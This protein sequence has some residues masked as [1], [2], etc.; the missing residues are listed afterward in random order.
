M[1]MRSRNNGIIFIMVMLVLTGTLLAGC[2]K[3]SDQPKESETSASES[4]ALESTEIP[5]E[6]NAEISE[7]AMQNFLDKLSNGNYTVDSAGYLKTTAYSED[8]V[9]FDYEDDE[10]YNDFAVMSVDHEVFQGSLEEDV[11]DVSFLREGSAL[12]TVINRLPGYWMTDEASGGNIYNVFYNDT[13]D[14]LKFV[15][16]DAGIQDHVRSLAGYGQVAVNYMH[17]VYLSMDQEDPEV[18]H[19]QAVVD[20]DEVARYYFD[21]IDITITF[22]DAQPDARAEAWMKAP[23]YPEARTQW[24]ES[25][26]FVFNSVFLPGYGDQAIPYIPFASYAL[27]VDEERFIS[28]DAVYIRDSHATQEDTENYQQILIDNGYEACTEDDGTWYRK[29]LRE[30]T[31]CYASISA[32]Y[33]DGLDVTAKKYYDFP[34]YE[35]LE[36]INELIAGNGYPGLSETDAMTV[37]DATD[38]KFEQTESWLYFYDYDIVLYVNARYEDPDQ[39]M[40]YLDS[41]ASEILKEGFS[42]VYVN[43][44]EAEGIDHYRSEDGSKTFRYHF[45]D[46]GETLTLLYK[47]EKC[48]TASQVQEILAEQGFP[49]PDMTAYVTGRDHKK[50]E[51]VLYGKTYDASLAITMR[52]DSSAAAEEYLNQYVG[53]LEEKDFFRVPASELGSNKTNGYTN[54]ETGQGVAFEL[55]PAEDGGETFI[56]FDFKS[57]IDFTDT[58]ADED[59]EGVKPILGTKHQE[60]IEAAH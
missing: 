22:G 33:N 46:D 15:S 48:L 30:E 2:S 39:V 41:Y 44:D 38:A 60:E 34:K 43:N 32:V 54:E 35:G 55:I 45:E 19:V 31:K 23:S 14:P 56:Y 18:V 42:P 40:A 52:F 47:A 36:Q 24:T 13:E 17:E 3:S 25:D 5:P 57:G 4:A 1:K 20:D 49:E 6:N 53:V 16:Y 8:L 26:I 58:D 50:F 37:L 59:D 7:R 27:T 12:E 28:D 10:S 11:S 29:L 21:D 9:Y 51:E